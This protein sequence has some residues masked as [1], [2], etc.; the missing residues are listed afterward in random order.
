VTLDTH[1]FGTALKRLRLG[2]NVSLREMAERCGFAPSEYSA[3]ERDRIPTVSLT[4]GQL[5]RIVQ[6]LS[7]HGGEVAYLVRAASAETA[8]PLTPQEVAGK[9]P[10]FIG[11]ELDEQML[12][13]L[14]ETIQN[15]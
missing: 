15:A 11:R 14:I 2:N 8:P 1:T 6:T 7:L 5:K 12:A 3:I 13:D 4:V 10:A 9:L